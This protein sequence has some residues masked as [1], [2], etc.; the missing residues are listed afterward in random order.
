MHYYKTLLFI[1]L[2]SGY[3]AGNVLSPHPHITIWIHGTRQFFSRYFFQKYFFCPPG[4]HLAS[5]LDSNLH[6]KEIAYL[7]HEVDPMRFDLE[8]FYIYGWSGRLSYQARYEAACTL[9][10]LI[11][12]VREEYRKKYG[13]W[14]VIRLI[15]HSHG[16]N[17]ALNLAKVE[18]HPAFCIDEL[19][20]LACPVQD[21]T[22]ALTAHYCFKRIISLYSKWDTLQVGDPQG[23]HFRWGREPEFCTEKPSS[24]FCGRIFPC[25]PH[26]AQA[27]I[28]INN[29]YLSHVGFLRNQFIKLLSTILDEIEE[30]NYFGTN[31]TIRMQT[32]TKRLWQ[33]QAPFFRKSQPA[34]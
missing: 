5:S 23:L 33:L 3:A 8:W 11:L 14:P 29:G 6:I 4:L 1:L 10:K 9:Y 26:I 22:K 2:Y 13:H 20:L 30:Q 34:T 18:D 21:Q 19:I 15:T 25:H 16:G 27:A 7:L 28:M 12:T 31:T 24:W 32:G 17:V